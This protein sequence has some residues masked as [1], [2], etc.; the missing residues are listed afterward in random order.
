MIR[1]LAPLR[2]WARFAFAACI[3]FAPPRVYPQ[4]STAS[5]TGVIRDPAERVVP[6][7]LVVMRNLE[8]ETERRTL[9]NSAGNYLV[10]N[11]LPGRYTLSASKTGFSTSII[12]EF[13]LAVDQRATVNIGL[14][15]GLL[16]QSVNVEAT[17]RRSR[18]PRP[19][20]IGG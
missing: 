8:T 13:T 3:V 14:E 9:S 10:G 16:E 5:V 18:A 15:L 17:G 20:W 12:Q 7:A 19:T 6:D 1:S 11:L 2:A 4:L